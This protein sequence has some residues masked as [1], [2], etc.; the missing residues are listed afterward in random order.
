MIRIM[1]VGSRND[2]A[3][4]R[5]PSLL[6]WDTSFPLEQN[7]L[8]SVISLTPC[9]LQAP[10]GLFLSEWAA[11]PPGGEGPHRDL[12][13]RAMHFTSWRVPGLWLHQD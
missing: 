4:S 13:A 11:Q 5:F 9:Q 1:R 3:V 7:Q 6:T 12:Q 2:V 8:C 10:G